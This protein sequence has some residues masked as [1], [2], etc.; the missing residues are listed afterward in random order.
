MK[1]NIAITGKK[2]Q[3]YKKKLL[4]LILVKNNEYHKNNYK[5]KQFH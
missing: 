3:K 4:T 1:Q 2:F 5:S